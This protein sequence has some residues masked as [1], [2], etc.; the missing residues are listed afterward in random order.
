MKKKKRIAIWLNIWFMP[1]LNFCR[2]LCVFPPNLNT[3]FTTTY[4]NPLHTLMLKLNFKLYQL[5]LFLLTKFKLSSG[6]QSSKLVRR[7]DIRQI[8]LTVFQLMFCQSYQG[9]IKITKVLKTFVCYLNWTKHYVSVNKTLNKL[10][11]KNN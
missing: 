9:N 4:S 6:H 7:K 8:H 1:Q 11:S 2:N 10:L 3:K 5:F